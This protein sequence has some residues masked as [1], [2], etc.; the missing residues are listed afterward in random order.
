[1]KSVR[2]CAG[3]VRCVIELSVSTGRAP[4]TRLEGAVE[5]ADIVESARICDVADI[6][7]HLQRIFEHNAAAIQSPCPDLPGD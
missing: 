1:M 3:P 4:E 6:D 5:M 7:V 2:F